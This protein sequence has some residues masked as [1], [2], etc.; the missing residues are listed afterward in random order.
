MSGSDAKRK[1]KEQREAGLDKWQAKEQEALEQKKKTKRRLWIAAPIVLVIVA[2]V[3]LM[4]SSLPYNK[5][6]ALQVGNTS[7]TAADFNYYYQTAYGNFEKNYSDM[8]STL[9][10]AGTLDRTI[11]LDQQMYSEE[12]TWGDYFRS[13]ALATIKETTALCEAAEEAGFTLPQEELDE[14]DAQLEA[15]EPMLPYYN[16]RNM[17]QYFRTY[18]GRGVTEEIFRRNVERVL[19]SAA[20]AE[21]VQKTMEFS[22]D[23]ILAEY[24]DNQGNYD[25]VIYRYFYIA[26]GT[27]ADTEESEREAGMAEAKAAAEEFADYADTEEKFM[28]RALEFM[29]ADESKTESEIKPYRYESGTL[30]RYAVSTLAESYADWL[31]D[32]SREYGDVAALESSNG[33]A[34][35]FFVGEDDSHY[36]TQNV[37]QILV[38]V[39]EDGDEDEPGTAL[40]E[41]METAEGYVQEWKDNGGT[42]EAFAQLAE[43]YSY[44]STTREDGG[45][46]ENVYLGQTPSEV[47]SWIFDADRKSG[48][49]EIVESEKGLH[50]LYYVEEAEPYWS[51]ASLNQ[52]QSEAF[53]AWKTELLEAYEPV[54]K[55][56]MKFINK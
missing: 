42:E 6:V 5:L 23:E 55:L 16:V 49:V 56:G 47:E 43:T 3:I 8:L 9:E 39:G 2:F 44:D 52:L 28:E 14:I 25:K 45:L 31:T 17:E 10:D 29:E 27:N 30:R 37:R 46:M 40:K 4:N 18:Y 1:R 22:E 21:H 50:I 51:A 12:E 26:S 33:Y 11:P 7:Y 24:T 19:L 32:S 34:V 48:D 53:E 20:Y 35:L 38:N 13:M 41:A 36:N 54:E 15:L